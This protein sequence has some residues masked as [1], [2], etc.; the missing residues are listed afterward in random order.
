MDYEDD[1][2]SVEGHHDTLVGP[3]EWDVFLLDHVMCGA[4]K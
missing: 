2:V 4:L 3:E 1:P